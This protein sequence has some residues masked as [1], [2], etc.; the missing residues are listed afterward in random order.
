MVEH[1]LQSRFD[2]KVRLFCLDSLLGYSCISNLFVLLDDVLELIE[3][4]RYKKYCKLFL[5]SSSNPDRDFIHGTDL[6][7]C[8]DMR[9]QVQS[10]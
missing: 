8:H 6:L 10:N 5:F 1:G 2:A 9:I 4:F 7:L 3:S